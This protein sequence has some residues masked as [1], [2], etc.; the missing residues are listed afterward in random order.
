MATIRTK[1]WKWQRA[2]RKLCKEN[3]I[4]S[5]LQAEIMSI[6]TNAYA[7]GMNVG[8]TEGHKDGKTMGKHLLNNK[9]IGT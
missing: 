2:T 1:L 4:E 7:D 5:R 9:I 6:V 3:G 8:Y